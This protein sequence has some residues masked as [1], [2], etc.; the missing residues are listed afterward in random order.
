MS[1]SMPL[2]TNE[3]LEQLVGASQEKI[4]KR[5]EEKL[6]E[7][8]ANI[9]ELKSKIVIHA[10]EFQKLKIKCDSNEQYVV[11]CACVYMVLSIMK[12]MILML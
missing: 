5:F 10:N 12:M 9:I 6:H 8:N 11:V 7:R 3:S 4:V 1:L 2:V